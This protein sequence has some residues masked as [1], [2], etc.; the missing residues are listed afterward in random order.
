MHRLPISGLVA[1]TE[2]RLLQ[3]ELVPLAPLIPVG[4]PRPLTVSRK[5][6]GN[7]GVSVAVTSELSLSRILG[8]ISAE[9][10]MVA[11]S[12]SKTCLGCFPIGSLVD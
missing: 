5:P 10:Y 12:I 7:P 8:C 1:L 4:Q 3:L 9:R 11:G 6:P 2:K